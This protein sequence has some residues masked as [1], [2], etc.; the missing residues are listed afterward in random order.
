MLKKPLF[1]GLIS[2]VFLGVILSLAGFLIGVRSLGF[3]E[4][5]IP[6]LFLGSLVIALIVGFVYHFT[7][8]F[9]PSKNNIIKAI[10]IWIIVWILVDLIP[11]IFMNTMPLMGMGIH[12][13]ANTTTGFILGYFYEN[14]KWS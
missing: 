9:L 1:S 12:L 10:L 8:K 7:L 5:E 3:P 14:K 11:G 2:G 13:I 4:I 6:F